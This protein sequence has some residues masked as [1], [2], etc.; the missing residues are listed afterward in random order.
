MSV[1]LLDLYRSVMAFSRHICNSF[2]AVLCYTWLK[3]HYNTILEVVAVNMES[4]QIK[5]VLLPISPPFGVINNILN[6]V[7]VV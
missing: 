7:S 4:V 6:N 3:S 2:L 1:E 5:I